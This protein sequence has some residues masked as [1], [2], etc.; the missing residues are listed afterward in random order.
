MVSVQPAETAAAIPIP[1]SQ[2]RTD[3][4]PSRN[5][6]RSGAAEAS[7]ASSATSTQKGEMDLSKARRT[8]VAPVRPTRCLRRAGAWSPATREVPQAQ[9]AMPAAISQPLELTTAAR[10]GAIGVTAI[11]IPAGPRER[12]STPLSAS[13]PIATSPAA[14]TKAT[15]RIR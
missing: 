4:L 11:T 2:S 7:R 10:N 15:R 5:C 9:R 13:T 12:P 14:T 6:R 1:A 8:A 3:R